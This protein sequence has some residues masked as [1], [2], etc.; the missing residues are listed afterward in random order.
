MG[1]ASHA[2]ASLV[3]VVGIGAL[4]TAIAR[5]SGDDDASRPCMANFK[6][7]GSVIRG[8]KLSTRQ[9]YTGVSYDI[10]F[11][12]VAQAT[13]ETGWGDMTATKDAGTITGGEQNAGIAVTIN[14]NQGGVIVVEAKIMLGP[15]VGYPEFKAKRALCA[16]VE[17]PGK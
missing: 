14:E 3:L 7:E 6:S 10:A 5:D 11:R 2:L 12:K 13:A 15:L 9:E 8:K 4:Q 1:M 16:S 17:A